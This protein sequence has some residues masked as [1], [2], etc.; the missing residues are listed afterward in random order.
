MSENEEEQRN[1]S[2]I[3]VINGGKGPNELIK[4]KKNRF[5]IYYPSKVEKWIEEMEEQGFLLDE[6]N[7]SG[8]VFSFSRGEKRK[9]KCFVDLP[10]II[11]KEYFRTYIKLGWKPMYNTRM[12]GG[13]MVLWVKSENKSDICCEKDFLNSNKRL[14]KNMLKVITSNLVN[15][16]I[17]F[18]FFVNMVATVY[19][20]PYL[21]DMFYIGINTLIALLA[22]SAFCFLHGSIAYFIKLK[23]L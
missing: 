14:T 21:V 6:I 13:K 19:K 5:F 3:K 1:T 16:L 2:Y 12:L 11:D 23:S 18:Y 17:A 15:F 9:T 10:D 8:N 7:R 22:F 20:S 4:I